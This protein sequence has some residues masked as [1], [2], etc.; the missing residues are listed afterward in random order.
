MRVNP[1]R[2][3]ATGSWPSWLEQEL[4]LDPE[5]VVLDA[6][7]PVLDAAVIGLHLEGVSVV[8]VAAPDP[9]FAHVICRRERSRI[10]GA[11]APR[12][13][14]LAAGPDEITALHVP[15]V[16][17]ELRHRSPGCGGLGLAL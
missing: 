9:P 17:F 5:L 4:G 1:R 11:V 8:V 10:E 13:L 16:R 12:D 2:A 3:R 15:A 7:R 6:G 14:P